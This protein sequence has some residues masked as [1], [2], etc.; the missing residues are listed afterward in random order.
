MA[1]IA[2]GFGAKW[3]EELASRVKVG[4]FVGVN[5]AVSS[6]FLIRFFGIGSLLLLLLLYSYPITGLLTAYFT[7]RSKEREEKERIPIAF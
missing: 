6:A 7:T 1:R 2:K 4:L 3:S 5:M